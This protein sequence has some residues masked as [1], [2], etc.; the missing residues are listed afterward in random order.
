MY[1]E[2]CLQWCGLQR[3]ERTQHMTHCLTRVALQAH[4]IC[5]QGVLDMDLGT[6]S[7]KRFIEMIA[8]AV[9]G[10]VEA[11]APPGDLHFGKVVQA[12]PGRRSSAV[13]GHVARCSSSMSV[14]MFEKE[15]SGEGCFELKALQKP[16]SWDLKQLCST[17]LFAGLHAW[18]PAQDDSQLRWSQGSLDT[19]HRGMSS[20]SQPI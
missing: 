8:A 7:P 3:V 19:V 12:W 18:V 11:S 6:A 13:P 1:T 4:A 15:V 14:S 20:L 17:K 5:M 2:C 9:G 10:H 16:T